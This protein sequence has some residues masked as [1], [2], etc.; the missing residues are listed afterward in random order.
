VAAT[1][2]QGKPKDIGQTSKDD[3]TIKP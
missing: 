1:E 2:K 3:S